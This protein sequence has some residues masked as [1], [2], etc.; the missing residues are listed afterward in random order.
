MLWYH[1]CTKKR[2]PNAQFTSITFHIIFHIIYWPHW[3]R[4]I[5][6]GPL[7]WNYDLSCLNRFVNAGQPSYHHIVTI[8]DLMGLTWWCW[9]GTLE[10]STRWTRGWSQAASDDQTS[11][12]LNTRM[13]SKQHPMIIH[14]DHHWWM[15][16]DIFVNKQL[17]TSLE[18]LCFSVF[19]PTKV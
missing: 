3:K 5:P 11:K 17:V 2:S 8:Y 7:R 16:R 19:S 9:E 14:F 13:I 4:K 6:D 12:L 18:K 1:V 15:Q 10:T